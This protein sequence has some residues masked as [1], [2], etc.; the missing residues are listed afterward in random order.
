[1]RSYTPT[2]A[3]ILA[4]LNMSS[5]AIAF[6]VTRRL[7]PTRGHSESHSTTGNAYTGKGGKGAGGSVN[8]APPCG[9]V[10]DGYHPKALIDLFSRMWMYPLSFA[11]H[12]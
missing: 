5:P 4:I 7:L 1:M 2:L 9:D 3:L 10:C 8:G 12:S 6:P 11:I